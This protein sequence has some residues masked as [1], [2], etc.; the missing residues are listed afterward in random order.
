MMNRLIFVVISL[1]CSVASA[2]SR[3][4]QLRFQINTRA[5]ASSIPSH[6]IS[7]YIGNTSNLF[8]PIDS[9]EFHTS[10]GKVQLTR[11]NLFRQYPWKRIKGKFILKAKIGGELPLE[12]VSSGFSFAPKDPEPVES[13]TDLINLFNY[14][15]HDPRVQAV[16]IEIDRFACGYAKLIELRRIMNYFR[17]SGK[18]IIGYCSSGAEKEI[19]V[20]LSCDQFF[21]PP[22]GGLDLRGFSGGATFFRGIFDKIGIEPQVQRIGKY[23]SFGDTFNRTSISDAQREVISSLLMESSNYWA[24]SVATG[25]NKTTD[26]V[27]KLWA[28]AG[29]K[30]ASDFCKMGYVSGVCYLDQVEGMLKVKYGVQKKPNVFKKISL[31]FKSLQPSSSSTTNEIM[32]DINDADD[33]QE[34]NL[35]KSFEKQPRRRSR[36]YSGKILNTTSTLF[37]PL[38]NNMAATSSTSSLSESVNDS[39]PVTELTESVSS[40][41]RDT[42][43]SPG[44]ASMSTEV[45]DAVGN[46]LIGTDA[47]A[48]DAVT[49][50]EEEKDMEPS[51][52][53]D[54]FQDARGYP[55]GQYLRKMRKG[56][57]ILAGLRVK[58]ALSGPRIAIINAVG[59]IGSGKSSRGPTGV[60]L[61][62]D[63]LIAMLRVAR[64]DS[65]IKGVVLRVDSPGGSALASDLMWRELRRLSKEK[66]VIAS[67]V[68]VSSLKAVY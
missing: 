24:S 43:P 53:K 27:M 20:G 12:A 2:L 40:E 58:E 31:L 33:L 45:S 25:R 17:K 51:K 16:F 8:E 46:E 38:D 35:L 26:E 37:G 18:E 67:M 19:F 50:T 44:F 28:D 41:A 66:P 4:S 68:D 11:W 54:D 48:T 55:A 9:P 63:S 30:E 49:T 52:D 64:Q 6:G 21:I 42:V 61:G 36:D 34:F 60:S 15:A 57:R 1:T 47:V 13:L 29:I 23:K 32:S 39:S 22:D 5:F 56:G 59:G 65:S 3:P 14:A 7:D 62:S 10:R